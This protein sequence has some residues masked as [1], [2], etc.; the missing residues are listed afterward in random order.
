MLSGP[1]RLDNSVMLKG[2]NLLFVNFAFLCL[3][4]K[5]ENSKEGESRKASGKQTICTVND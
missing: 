3:F 2:H 4:F 5:I 1:L